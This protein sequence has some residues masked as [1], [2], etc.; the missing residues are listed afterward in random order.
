M[1]PKRSRD[2]SETIGC[3]TVARGISAGMKRDEWATQTAGRLLQTHKSTLRKWP[4]IDL[5]IWLRD[6]CRC[7]Y[8]DR[9]LLADFGITYCLYTY[10]HL[11]PVSKYP[12]LKDFRWNKVLACRHCNFWKGRLDPAEANIPATEDSRDRLIERARAYIQDRQK[13]DEALFLKEREIL[14]D[15]LSLWKSD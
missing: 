6:G 4:R 7:V 2:Y 9:D 5:E 15:A 8:C 11:L 10:D 14:A 3:G 12:A 13:N 1:A